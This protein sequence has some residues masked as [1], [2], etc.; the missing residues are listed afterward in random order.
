MSIVFN[1][2]EKITKE[3]Q[4]SLRRTMEK[5]VTKCRLILICENLGNLI[6]ALL[7]RCFLIRC[8]GPTDQ[9]MLN[10]LQKI[11]VKENFTYEEALF[12]KIVTDSNYNLRRAIL[13]LQNHYLRKNSSGTA[14]MNDWRDSVKSIVSEVKKSQTA[15][16]LKSVR[17]Y[18]LLVNCVP[19]GMI[20]K[21]LIV[22]FLPVFESEL[23]KIEL[24]EAGAYYENLLHQG[25]KPLP[26]IEAFL[27]KVMVLITEEGQE[28]ARKTK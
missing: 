21:E 18:D 3:A 10:S 23:N 8:R 26:F 1:E 16:T 6:P 11:S 24:V 12:R 7:S 20:F 22:Q 5:Y 13:G 19:S 9:E 15:A 14:K 27:A 28:R 25:S 2:A 4:A 17:C